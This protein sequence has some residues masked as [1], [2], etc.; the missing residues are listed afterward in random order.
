MRVVVSVIAVLLSLSGTLSGDPTDV[1][2]HS[3]IFDPAS[4]QVLFTIEFDQ[5]PDFFALDE[6]DR[7]RDSFQFYVNSNPATGGPGPYPWDRIVR[8][9]EIHFD[10]DVRI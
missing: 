4:Q 5:P 2:S 10:N 9:D 7:Q 1:F 6:F 8:G 3:V